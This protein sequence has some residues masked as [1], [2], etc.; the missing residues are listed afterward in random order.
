M[1]AIKEATLVVKM[2]AK[3]GSKMEVKLDIKFESILG[4]IYGSK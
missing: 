2:E 4:D 1:E 3:C